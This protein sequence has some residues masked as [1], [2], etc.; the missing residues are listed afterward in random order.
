M[1]RLTH[2]LESD[3]VNLACKTAFLIIPGSGA[4]QSTLVVQGVGYHNQI[5]YVQNACLPYGDVFTYIKPNEDV[6]AICWNKFKLSNYLISYLQNNGKHYGVNYLIEIIATLQWMKNKY[7]RVVVLGLSEGGYAAMLASFYAKP[8]GAVIS[9][10]YSIHFDSSAS[11]T[12]LQE[13]FDSLV[14]YSYQ[15]SCKK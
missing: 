10:A 8:H 6:R 14:E 7:E 12:I 3:T 9:S 11:A 5:C 15:A 4:D 2:I 13:R 1:I